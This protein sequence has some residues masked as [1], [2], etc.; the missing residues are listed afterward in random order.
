MNGNGTHNLVFLADNVH[1]EQCGV[2]PSIRR[3]PGMYHGYFEGT[4]GD[5]W[6][7]VIDRKDKRGVLRGGDAGWKNEY[8]VVD[9][10]APQLVLGNEEQAWLR[11]CWAAAGLR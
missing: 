8:E 6:V 3:T 2:P 9:G 4:C 7:L 11:A 10:K 5:Q 1:S